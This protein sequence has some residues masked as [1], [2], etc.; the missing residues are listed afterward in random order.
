MK[1]PIRG[2]LLTTWAGATQSRNSATFPI[3]LLDNDDSDKEPENTSYM[4]TRVSFTEL[5]MSV[6][7]SEKKRL[8]I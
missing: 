5:L 7:I 3:M 8:C 4:L 2:I 1:F 6:G